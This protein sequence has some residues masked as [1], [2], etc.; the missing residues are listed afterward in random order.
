VFCTSGRSEIK[1]FFR[2]WLNN[3]RCVLLMWFLVSLLFLLLK[4]FTHQQCYFQF[5]LNC[6]ETAATVAH[7]RRPHVDDLRDNRTIL[8]YKPEIAARVIRL[9]RR[10][11]VADDPEVIELA[12]DVIDLPLTS[13]KWLSKNSDISYATPQASVVDR[14]L[15]HKVH[16]KCFFYYF[17]NFLHRL[18][19]RE[20][21][22]H[23]DRERNIV[24]DLC[25]DC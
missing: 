13:S 11:A 18:M 6:T 24:R 3:R 7:P 15:R 16:Q 19:H 20:I 14:Y 1:T 4:I 23:N 22:A 8:E 10:R 9:N 2:S 21:C 5:P 25:I 17:V 12:G